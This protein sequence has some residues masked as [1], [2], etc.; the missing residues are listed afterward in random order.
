VTL[1]T[2]QVDWP[3]VVRQAAKIGVKHYFIEDETATAGQQIP[4]SLEYLRGL[5]L[6]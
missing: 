2:G 6:D 5:N 3:T 1:G 4:K